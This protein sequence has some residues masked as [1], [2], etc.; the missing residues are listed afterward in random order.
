MA[1]KPGTLIRTAMG[2]LILTI[3][4]SV[5]SFGATGLSLQGRILKSNNTPVTSSSVQFR[6]QVRSPGAEN[7][8]LFEETQ[9]LDMSNSQGMF[10][11]TL[12]NGTRPSALIDG[13]YNLE[14]IFA[15]RGSIDLSATA[16]AACAVGTAYTPTTT[17]H[18]KIIYY[19]N[20]GSG[21]Q[22]VPSM[23]VNWVPYAL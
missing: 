3:F 15:N 13:G 19:F 10:S 6:I 9:T 17:A 22:S 18:R 4:F 20:D 1:F 5:P 21:W 8:L 23:T 11:L 2:L 14:R 16:P 12:G 7:C